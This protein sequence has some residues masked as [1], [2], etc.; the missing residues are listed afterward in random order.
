MADG[1][2]PDDSGSRASLR[3]RLMAALSIPVYF[4]VAAFINIWLP[5][6]VMLVMIPIILAAF[7]TYFLI[8]RR[9]DENHEP[10]E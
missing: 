2:D 3:I 8:S 9:E 6:L 1:I 10:P 5:H 4:C 7:S